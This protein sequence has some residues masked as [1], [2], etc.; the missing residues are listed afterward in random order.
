M[1]RFVTALASLALSLSIPAPGAFAQTSP[2]PS[3]QRDGQQDF[4]WE[5]GN[6]TT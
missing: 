4:D 5:I 3:T 6:W 1:A 2:A